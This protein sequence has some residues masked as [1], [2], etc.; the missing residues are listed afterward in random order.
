[1]YSVTLKPLVEAFPYLGQAMTVRIVANVRAYPMDRGVGVQR[2]ANLSSKGDCSH[3]VGSLSQADAFARAPLSFGLAGSMFTT[4]TELQQSCSRILQPSLLVRAT[5][6]ARSPVA[7]P[8]LA[9][10]EA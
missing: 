2:I 8:T 9:A 1:N 4:F 7:S 3:H 10:L 5:S 6:P